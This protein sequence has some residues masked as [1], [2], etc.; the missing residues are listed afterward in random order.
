MAI[1]LPIFFTSFVFSCFET[2]FEASKEHYFHV[3]FFESKRNF[4][5]ETHLFQPDD[6]LS[7]SPFWYIRAVARN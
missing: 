4:A 7:S 6:A 5:S 2:F 1:I 3:L